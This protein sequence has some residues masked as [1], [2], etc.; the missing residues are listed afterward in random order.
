[1]CFRKVE[2]QCLWFSPALAPSSFNGMYILF[3][4]VRD[5]EEE[6]S[7]HGQ[8]EGPTEPELPCGCGEGGRCRPVC[9]HL[10]PSS[11]APWGFLGASEIF[12]QRS[13]YS[14]TQGQ[15]SRQLVVG[16]MQ[17][18]PREEPGWRDSRGGA[19]EEALGS[20]CPASE[21]LLCAFFSLGEGPQEGIL[22]VHSHWG[23]TEL[24][25]SLQPATAFFVTPS[26][27]GWSGEG[28]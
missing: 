24:S 5:R 15:R 9:S 11:K 22:S 10:V 17:N 12:G 2:E 6:Q 20:P 4:G 18:M 13:S 28:G 3:F 19:W 16:R 1:M 8:A 7:E 21:L 27:S 25:P 14:W 26:A 23:T